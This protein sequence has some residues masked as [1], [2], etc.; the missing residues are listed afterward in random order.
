MLSE[1]YQPTSLSSSLDSC[2]QSPLSPRSMSG[3]TGLTDA[4]GWDRDACLFSNIYL[5]V[6]VLS[7]TLEI[8]SCGT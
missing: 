2:P 5:A 6:L 4:S 1:F 8:F 7:C 3:W